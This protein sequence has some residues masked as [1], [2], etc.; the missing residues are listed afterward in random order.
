MDLPNAGSFAATERGITII[1]GDRA[2]LIPV[3]WM[4]WAP[5]GR[6][7]ASSIHRL[8]SGIHASMA[9]RPCSDSLPST[10]AAAAAG[11][12]SVTWTS[13][14]RPSIWRCS[15]LKYL[16][17]CWMAGPMSS[18]AAILTSTGCRPHVVLAR[19]ACEPSAVITTA[20]ITMAT[21][22]RTP[23]RTLRW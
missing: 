16:A 20:A 19:I 23:V 3:G 8:E 7:R 18:E 1:S 12:S 2:T 9:G 5:T 13:A 4:T 21:V 14:H 10:I 22:T 15:R 17:T 11:W 6:L